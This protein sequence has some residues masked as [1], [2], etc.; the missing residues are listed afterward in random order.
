MEECFFLAEEEAADVLEF[1][2][3]SWA[4]PKTSPTAAAALPLK[5]LNPALNPAAKVAKGLSSFF[6][7]SAAGSEPP[8]VT[9]VFVVEVLARAEAVEASF[10]GRGGGAESLRP[11]DTEETELAAILT[12]EPAM[13][14]KLDSLVCM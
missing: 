13:E 10:G 8:E 11:I 12:Q 6:A 2:K 7:E 14:D 9:S 1:G 3:A 4:C 5:S